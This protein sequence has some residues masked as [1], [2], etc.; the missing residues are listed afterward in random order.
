MFIASYKKLFMDL[1]QIS[2]KDRLYLMLEIN[3]SNIKIT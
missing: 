3:S 1:S 2:P